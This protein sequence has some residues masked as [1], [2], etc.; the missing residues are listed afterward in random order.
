MGVL[1]H[2]FKLIQHLYAGQTIIVNE[3]VGVKEEGKTQFYC[4]GA[5]QQR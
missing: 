1:S 2:T 5:L 3:A 4:R